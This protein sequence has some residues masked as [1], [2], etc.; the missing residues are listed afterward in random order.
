VDIVTARACAPMSRLLGF[1]RPYLQKGATGLFL[2]GQDVV[3]E[4]EDAS[5][6]WK[7]SHRL[8]AS[9]SDPRGRIVEVKGL[10]RVR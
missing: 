6:S 10:S 3:S 9:L 7:F 1:A 2:K 8:I 5:T 4:I